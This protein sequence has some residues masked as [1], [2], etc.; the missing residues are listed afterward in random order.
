VDRALGHHRSFG[1]VAVGFGFQ[2]PSGIGI[3]V[4]PGAVNSGGFLFFDALNH[5]Y[6]GVLELQVYSVNVKAFG[7]VETKLR[8]VSGLLFAI[9]ISAEFTP[10]QLGLG[11]T[12]NASAASGSSRR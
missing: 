7:V 6:G 9:V 1:D 3:S 11:F 8:T 4:D 2:P 10:I 5:R 12:L